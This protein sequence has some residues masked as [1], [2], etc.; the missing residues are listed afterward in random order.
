MYFVNFLQKNI[1][2]LLEANIENLECDTITNNTADECI[3]VNDTLENNTE[4]NIVDAV[5]SIENNTAE[6]MTIL[7]I[8]DTCTSKKGK[9]KQ[10][11]KCEEIIKKQKLC[12]IRMQKKMK[13][14]KYMI[15]SL[16]QK[17]NN[18]KSDKYKKALYEI[19]TEDQ[20]T[21]LCTKTQK[22]PKN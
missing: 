10:K 15:H 11:E 20:I 1:N 5:Q 21:A 16:R 19:F 7:T 12:M 4:S 17:V 13:A 2:N 9:E 6:C 14:M 8:S 22:R 18:D 3:I